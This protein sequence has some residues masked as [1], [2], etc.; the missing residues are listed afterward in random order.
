MTNL[1]LGCSNKPEEEMKMQ[2]L[3]NTR[4]QAEKEAYKFGCEGAHQM[5]S[6]WMPCSMHKH[7]H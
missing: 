4:E 7:N 2:M 5:G 3:F 1:T 6:K